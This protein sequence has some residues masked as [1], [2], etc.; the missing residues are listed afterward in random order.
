VDTYL[1][2]KTLPHAAQVTVLSETILKV[3]GKTFSDD[4]PQLGQYQ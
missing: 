3:A 2:L 1:I 4:A